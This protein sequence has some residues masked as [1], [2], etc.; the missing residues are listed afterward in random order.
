VV[1]LKGDGVDKAVTG[2]SFYVF[3]AVSWK[4][5]VALGF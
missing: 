3:G 1:K 4:G 2:V 5:V